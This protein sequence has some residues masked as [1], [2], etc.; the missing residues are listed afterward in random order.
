M[1][2]RVALSLVSLTLGLIGGPRLWDLVLRIQRRVSW[3]RFDAAVRG[4]RILGRLALER[5]DLIIAINDGLIPASIV[6]RNLDINIGYWTVSV[7]DRCVVDTRGF[8][9]DIAG[10]KVVLLDD[11]VLAGKRMEAA[12]ARARQLR[13]ADSATIQRMTVFAQ[14]TPLREA[15]LDFEPAQQFH[16]RIR[17]M[18]WS[19]TQGHK[20]RYL[21]R[22]SRGAA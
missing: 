2:V 9:P 8:E 22:A 1:D 14:D 13:G 20:T 16:G 15:P 4:S 6:A 19:Y 18:P 5:P 7:D 21:P 3:R 12:F 10:R 17:S 11:Q